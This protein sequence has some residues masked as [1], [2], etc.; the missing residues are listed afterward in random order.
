MAAIFFV[1]ADPQPPAPVSVSDKV[2]HL[3]AYCG[4]AV[5]VFRAVARGIPARV[6]QRSAAATL[7][8]TIA[9]GI[10]DELHQL[11]VPRRSAELN[12]LYADI[13][14]AAIGLIGCW[15]WGIIQSLIA[16]PQSR[17]GNPKS[18]R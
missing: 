1:S 12:D 4:L 17:I 9:Y 5:L 13:A 2:M 14:G 7:L 6:T 11:Y 15:A 3:L 10:S 18:Q 16:N 8:I